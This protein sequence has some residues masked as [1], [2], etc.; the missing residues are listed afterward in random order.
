MKENELQCLKLQLKKKKSCNSTLLLLLKLYRRHHHNHLLIH[1]LIIRVCFSYTR[2][3]RWDDLWRVPALSLLYSESQNR[4]C[5]DQ[6]QSALQVS[7]FTRRTSTCN[8]ISQEFQIRTI[9]RYLART[10]ILL[11][12]VYG[13][14]EC[15]C[16]A[17]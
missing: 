15:K 1:L 9:D 16:H 14:S 2:P 13:T 8:L 17:V 10:Y 6:Q 3:T 7:E 5:H 11:Q 4:Q 12:E